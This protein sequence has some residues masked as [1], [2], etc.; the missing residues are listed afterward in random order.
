MKIKFLNALISVNSKLTAALG[1]LFLL[2]LVLMAGCQKEDGIVPNGNLSYRAAGV[3]CSTGLTT[4]YP[5]T[6]VCLGQ[7]FT[8]STV[9]NCG[10][11]KIQETTTNA[12]CGSST[13]WTNVAGDFTCAGVYSY[14]TAAPRPAG[15]YHFRTVHLQSVTGQCS[16]PTCT[17]FTG[18][19]WCC[20]D[21]T[22][23]A[24]GCDDDLEASVSCA[25][26][27]D[28]EG[29]VSNRH[30]TFTYTAGADVDEIVIQGG[31]THFTSICSKTATGGLVENTTHPSVLNSN[32]NVTRWEASGVEECDV[33]TVTINWF[34]TNGDA[35]ITGQWTVKDGDGNT[36][37]SIDPLQCPL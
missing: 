21:V 29:C 5:T 1:G 15:V 28:A 14:T 4:T 31:L 20:F 35:D 16:N 2:L 19:Q 18:E 6:P 25:T 36:L 22:V 24:C 12:A 13:G 34:S 8:L 17:S 26:T 27:T 7:N 33:F 37:A 11:W 3:N 10:R 9:G 23:A 32:A 30:V